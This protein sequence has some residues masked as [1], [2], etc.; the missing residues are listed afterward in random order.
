MKKSACFFISFFMASLVWSQEETNPFQVSAEKDH[1]ERTHTGAKT[2]TIRVDGTAD[3]DATSTCL[4]EG[5]TVG[6]Q[7]NVAVTIKNTGKIPVINPRISVNG[8]GGWLKPEE[9]VADLTQGASNEQERLYLMVE[10]LRRLFYVDVPIAEVEERRDPLRL[11]NIYGGAPSDDFAHAMAGL[12]MLAGFNAANGGQDPVIRDLHG[13]TLCEVWCGGAYQCMDVVN[14]TFFLDRGNQKP[15]GGDALIL[16][17]DLISRELMNGLSGQDWGET[18]RSLTPYFGPDDTRIPAVAP[19]NAMNFIL[20]PG[21]SIRYCWGNMGKRAWHVNDYTPKYYGNSTIIYEAPISSAAPKFEPSAM[22]GFTRCWWGLEAESNAASLTLVA[23]TPYIICGGGVR[24][25]WERMPASGTVIMEIATTEGEFKEFWRS[26]EESSNWVQ[27]LTDTVLPVLGAPPLRKYW[28]RVSFQNALG[29]RLTDMVLGTDV[30]ANPF[31]LPRLSAGTNQVRYSDDTAERHSVRIR[32]EWVES[33][34]V[35]PPVPPQEPDSPKAG[36]TV[37]A[38][39]GTFAWP[40]V[41]G[42]TAYRLRVSRDPQLRYPYRPG[43]DVIVTA[44]SYEA[45]SVGLFNPG[46]TYYW[47]VRPRLENGMWGA[48]SPTWTFQWEGPLAP[49]EL[50]VKQEGEGLMLSWTPNASGTP[51]VSYNVYGCDR[52]G[53]SV[54]KASSLLPVLGSVPG[55]FF[56]V[57]TGTSLKIAGS[58]LTHENANRAYY[59]VT[60]MDANGV[61]S[62]SSEYVETPR[63]FVYT[64]PITRV[65]A[66]GRYT[67]LIRS[68]S[69]M[70]SLQ[71]KPDGSLVWDKDVFRYALVRGPK[72]LSFDPET[73]LLRGTPEQGD[74]GKS[75]VEVRVCIEGNEPGQAPKET[76]CAFEL[77]VE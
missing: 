20:R 57:T 66:G 64:Q 48:W 49:Q 34:A 30:Y 42:C 37:R 59:R 70:G 38:T 28:F 50:Q 29:A 39:G 31:A 6:F 24:A 71:A 45:P 53:F 43:F 12:F 11:L 27:M 36:E 41:E 72:W 16:D 67:C 8:T 19:A 15:L 40:A 73:G 52:R 61:E 7:N 5:W 55:N 54:S 56:A 25:G 76:I 9:L 63:P 33:G 60:A 75:T 23:E 22:E 4:R 35:Q 17:Q 21:E 3:M 10:R 65:R 44:P 26:S 2:Y 51:A 13:P 68:I 74:R 62:G 69:S 46:E 77:K 14:G 1:V 58:D 47:S 32:H 18:A